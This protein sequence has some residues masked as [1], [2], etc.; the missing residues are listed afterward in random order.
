MLTALKTHRT[1]PTPTPCSEEETEAQRGLQLPQVTLWA[2]GVR[3]QIFELPVNTGFA[4]M[5]GPA[6][7]PFHLAN[8]FLCKMGIL[9]RGCRCLSGLDI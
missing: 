4:P 5:T 3:T 1:H 2:V 7:V 6:T 8:V 9:A